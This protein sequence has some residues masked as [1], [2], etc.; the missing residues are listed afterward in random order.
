MAIRFFLLVMGMLLSA[1]AGMAQPAFS[2]PHGLY[3]ESS[4]TVTIYPTSP[5]AEIF[6]TTD[7]SAPT[8][9]STR[10][11]APL[12]LDKTTLLRAIEVIDG[13][14]SAIATAS[15]ILMSSVLSQSNNPAGYPSTWGKYTT[16]SGNATADYEMDPEMTGNSTLRPKII[17][18]LKQ[19][20]ILSVVTDKD[21][22]FSHVNDEDKGGIY[23]FTGP[24]VGDATGHGWTRQCS[25]EL[26]GGP[27]QHDLT[28]S[29]G[30]KL[31][32]GHGRLAEKNPKHSFRLQFKKDYGPSSL[33]YPVFGDSEPR[34]FDQ[35]IL[36]C[37][38]GNSWQHWGEGNR[39][40]AQ[41]TRD[42]WARRMQRKISNL[43]ADALYVHLFLNGMYWG[44]YNIAERIDDA[45][46][47]N[48]IGGK[49][50]D[51]DVVK[52]EEDGGNHIEASEGTLD[53]WNEMLQTVYVA[54]GK[55]VDYYMTPEEAYAKLD[56]LLD[57]DNFIDYMI[58]N[59]YAGNGDW[60]HHNWYAIRRRG[61][62][63]EGFKFLCW[64]SEIIF[65]GAAENSVTKYNSG[66]PTDIFNTLLNNDDFALRYVRRA[67][68]LLSDDGLLGQR[69]V[70]QVW[71]SLYNNIS[72]AVYDEAARWGDYRRDV[73]RWQDVGKLYTVDD[74]YMSERNRLLTSYFPVR[75]ANT[76]AQIRSYVSVDDFVVPDNWVKM[77][78]EMFRE[79]DGTGADARPLNV[80]INPS[81]NLFADVSNGGIIAGINS[82][83]HNQFADLS[84][85]EKLVLR[86]KSGSNVRLLA[87]RLV[88]HGEWKEITAAFSESDPYWDAEYE[89]L[90]I[91]LADIRN[92]RTS[93]NNDRADDFVHLNAIKANWNATANIEGIYLVPPGGESGIPIDEENFPDDNFRSYLLSQS[94]GQDGMLTG[95]EAEKVTRMSVQNRNIKNMAGIEHFTA[96]ISFLCYQNNIKGTDMDDLIDRLPAVSGGLLYAIHS[97]NEGNVM[98]TTQVAAAK[99]KGW[100][101]YYH[102]G[103]RWQRYEGSIPTPRG[104]ANGDGEIGMPD[105]M[106]VVNYILGNPVETFNEKAADA[107]GDGEIGMPDVMFIVNYI[108]NGKYPDE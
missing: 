46:G 33:D 59:H 70:V 47:R 88:A 5:G 43:G 78:R 92:K 16:I 64:D 8:T 35:L 80:E 65:G 91:P 86:G 29:C 14:S 10:Y 71:D 40:V 36:R 96:M 99:A 90:V 28:V 25:A 63:S 53:A 52:I 32:G 39:K 1:T 26:F 73:H 20:P 97:S 98:T 27:Q 9:E 57:K 101:P 94:Y 74:T 48:H 60:D 81:W 93:S 61:N 62:D 108:L 67:K 95:K 55:T 31:H 66:G 103:T 30:I 77:S 45:F 107:N 51:Y 104:D 68:E 87:N 105:V 84:K 76:L 41:Y 58:I 69:S 38:F 11:T 85:Y 22:L 6:Y 34:K 19:L 83:E 12:T 2:K 3:E 50:S 37:H 21:N 75:S 4:I 13:S 49:K 24:P 7:G 44:I 54:G 82:V 15:Y 102:D 56:T 72:L 89:A 23:I 79:W 100:V 18:G 17:E 42:V 106:F